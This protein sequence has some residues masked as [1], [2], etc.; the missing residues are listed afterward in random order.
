MKRMSSIRTARNLTLSV[1][2]LFV[3]ALGAQQLVAEKS[4][5]EQTAHNVCDMITR[6]HISKKRIDDTISEKLFN[7]YI[8]DLDSQKLYFL[9]S[10]IDA[11]SAYKTNLDD[12]VKVGNVDFAYDVFDLFLKRLDERMEYADKLVDQEYDFTKD[13]TAILDGDELDWAPSVE[14]INERWRKR[15]KFDLL[16]LKLDATPMDEAR[17]RLHKRYHLLKETMHQTEDFETFETY[18]SSL[19]HCFDPHSTYMSPQ[20]L[21]EFQIQMRLSLQGIGA[22]LTSEDGMTVINKIIPGGAAAKDKRLEVGDKIV[23]VAQEE[24]EWVDVVEMKLS[25]VVRYIRGKAGTVVKLKVEKADSGESVVYELIRQKVELTES[26]VSGQIIDAK[27][28]FPNGDPGRIGVIHIPSFY[29]DFSG[30]QAG[31]EDFRSTSRDVLGVLQEFRK[32]G[33]VDAIMIDLRFNGGGALSEA[34]D[35]SGLFV[36]HGPIVQIKD[37]NGRVKSHDFDIDGLEDPVYSGPLLVVTN[38]LSASASEIFAGAIKDYGRGIV[39]GD[40]TTHG[41]GT[42]QNVVE[43]GASLFNFGNSDSSGALKVT[44]N[45]FYRPNGDSTQREGVKSDIVLP[46]Q[47]DHLDLGEASLDNAMAFDQVDPVERKQYGYATDKLIQQLTKASRQRVA[48]SEHFQKLSE[49]IDRYLERKNRVKIPLKEEVL[50]AER[51]AEEKAEELAEDALEDAT[52]EDDENP[53][54]KEPYNEEL[55]HIAV[56]YLK[57]LENRKTAGN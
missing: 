6:Y 36:G 51:E 48:S 39:I 14:A 16:S 8:S 28:W 3:C 18:L 50:K 43:V 46:S 52:T 26:A 37:S 38:K 19:T 12:L 21:E 15:V 53:F 55:I 34:I 35:V 2:I 23:A 41:K 44:I 30:A 22:Q 24:G 57:S 4:K 47:I 11:Y 31:R 1:L 42:V 9:K 27:E 7:K 54:K 25:K 40:T 45:Q 13:E 5:D 20:T 17:E 56:D 29:R 32:A 49:K 10:D 33:G